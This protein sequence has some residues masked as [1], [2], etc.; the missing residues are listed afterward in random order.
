MVSRLLARAVLLPFVFSFVYPQRGSNHCFYYRGFRRIP[1]EKEP[2]GCLGYTHD[3]FRRDAPE[4]IKTMKKEVYIKKEKDSD[5]DARP[6][7]KAKTGKASPKHSRDDAEAKVDGGSFPPVRYGSG[8]G[9]LGTSVSLR[10]MLSSSHDTLAASRQFQLAN[11]VSV[12]ASSALGGHSSL[13]SHQHG[14]TQLE[15]FQRASLAL[16]RP[17]S[18]LQQSRMAQL[19][20]PGLLAP[21]LHG[22]SSSSGNFSMDVANQEILRRLSLQRQ[23]DLLQQEQLR[24]GESLGFPS[25]SSLAYEHLLSRR[26]SML[27]RPLQAGIGSSVFGDVTSPFESSAARARL[28]LEQQRSRASMLSDQQGELAR[29]AYMNGQQ[30]ST[31]ETAEMQRM[32]AAVASLR[33]DEEREEAKR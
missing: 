20:P 21:E 25:G 27:H 31:T 7:K 16:P 9:E 15:R 19:Q 5:A 1:E 17:L 23:V 10:D 4:L 12:D 29:R 32:R 3:A 6:K 33:R 8:L 24:R 26:H 30:V 13:F 2:E 28:L 22:L 14:L 11:M 18:S